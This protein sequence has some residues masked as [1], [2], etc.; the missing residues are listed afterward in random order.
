M[1]DAILAGAP[2]AVEVGGA[3]VAVNSGFRQNLLAETMDRRD[4]ADA[5]RLL[6]CWFGDGTGRLRPGAVARPA[7]ALAAAC[8]WH[9]AAWALVSYGRPGARGGGGPRR[10]FDW[11]A[12]SGILC[13]D[14]QRLYGIDLLDP[15]LRMHWYRFMALALSAMRTPGSLVAA[16]LEA[17]SPLRGR[18]SDAERAAHERRAAAWALPPT[19]AELA[20][21]ARREF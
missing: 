19:D 10:V 6:Q 8:A 15:S 14:F 21:I 1:L 5:A 12:D 17:R 13:A 3:P 20:E 16:A 7:E 2:S 11:D 18:A 9:D 4:R